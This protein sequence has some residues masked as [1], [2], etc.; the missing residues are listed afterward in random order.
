[1]NLTD[2]CI[3]KPVFAWMLMAAT[4]VFG[5]I[6][7]TRIGISQFPDVDFPTLSINVTWEGAAP[8]VV[9]HDVIE[10]LEEA[11]V[12]VEGV[13]SITSSSRQGGGNITVELDLARN[14]DLAMQDVQ[15]K[16]SQA[17]RRLPEDI[18]PPVISK[19][20]P[21]DQPI[22][23]VGLSGPFPPRVLSDFARYRLKEKLQTVPGIGEIIMGGFVERNIRVWL[24][25]TRLDE[26]GLTVTDVIEALQR[27]H[28]ELPAGRIETEG[29]EVNV[30][31]LGEALDLSTFRRIVVGNT[32]EAPV[33]LEDV[34]L[35]EDG[36]EDIRRLSRV[37][38]APAQGLGIKKQRGA[39]AVA[40]AR[41]IRQAMEELR[42]T[43]PEGM[44]LGV[45]FDSTRF[46]E[47]SVH[48]VE[49]ELVMA[50]I[51]T[52]VVCWLFLGSLSST[53]NVVLA[54][55][56]SLLGTIATI[57]FLG[58]TLN[59]FTLLALSLAVGIVV[60]DAI[61]ILENIFRHS[62]EGKDRVR[63]S[64][65]GTE[66]IK[67]AALAATLAVIAIF[68]PV[69]F[70]KGVIGRFF[71]QFGVTL[72]V[73]VMLSYLEAI[74]LAPARCAQFLS[75]SREGRS[76][77]GQWGDRGFEWLAHAYS[78]LLARGLR[79]P[80]AILCLAA[81][82][83]AGSFLVLTRLPKEFVPSQDQSRLLV[84]LQTA[85]GSNLAETDRIFHRA[86]AFM[87][88]RPEV[89]RAYAIVGGFGGGSV[90]TGVMFVTLVPPRERDLSQAEFAAVIRK[91][92]NSYP[93]V[94]AVVQDLSQQGFTAQ[95]GFP[96]EFSVRGPDWDRLVEVSREIERKL[97]ASGAVID[98]DSDYQV[99]MPELRISPDRA[100]AADLGISV[101]KVA[102]TINAMVGGLRVGRYSTEGRR[103]DVRLRLLAD[104]RSRPEDLSRLR[105]RS[106]SDELIPLSSLVTY[107]ERPALQ[108][109]TRSDRERA[110]TFFANVA[111]GRS[112][113][114]ALTLVKQLSKELPIGYHAVLGGASVA[115]QESMGSLVFA[116]LLGVVVAYM[117]LA[118]QFNSLLHPVTVLTILPLSIAG[119]AI[120]LLIAGK[121]LNIFSMIGLLLLMGIVKKNSIIL[122]DYALQIREEGGLDAATAML[123]AGP[124]R[125]RPILMTS[126]ATMMA[127]VPAALAL[128][129]GS[130]V[131][132]PMAMAVIGGL[133]VSTVLSLFVVPAFY[134]VAD[135]MAVKVQGWRSRGR[136]VG[137]VEPKPKLME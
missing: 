137:P 64:R 89:A 93:G 38:G 91:E 112:Q 115:F 75:T 30:R 6:A 105:V 114:E 51:L 33:Y 40:L 28:V 73:A 127:A 110:I 70:M 66:Q 129:S 49:F 61:M 29:R 92:I 135:R 2:I 52:A 5:G 134:V 17:Q 130:E 8:E 62:E 103:I 87:N 53:L 101:E 76:R 111:P 25:A 56:M 50:V 118:S 113:D 96:V 86:E 15:S 48:E 94:R 35:V 121:S 47:E 22:M 124:V 37:A 104:Q 126:V 131:R 43:L 71:L 55:P 39:N 123:R 122:V 81:V 42:P 74:T 63:A 67:F 21:E 36:F 102:Q 1:M 24:D 84:R 16:V 11:V 125:L 54:I 72:S 132:S 136:A 116:I 78:G 9:E 128:G 57:Y 79:W 98:L 45:N 12:Q 107:E 58:F 18:D 46:I 14:V 82:L 32:K 99:G 106:A 19:T 90:N 85:V 109:I 133:I 4:V 68:I 97:S 44:E 117:I 120:A 10:I 60:D 31:I 26:K 119:A 65:E 27:E 41:G 100:R 20:N 108:A 80:V 59:T 13:R 69:I 88:A 95:R 77:L 23:W 7:A 34:A 83:F 3:K